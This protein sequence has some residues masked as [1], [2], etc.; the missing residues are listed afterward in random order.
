MQQIMSMYT[1]PVTRYTASL[2]ISLNSFP[3]G[4]YV[5]CYYDL[6]QQVDYAELHSYTPE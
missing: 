5:K 6:L 4:V 3:A 2:L 1:E